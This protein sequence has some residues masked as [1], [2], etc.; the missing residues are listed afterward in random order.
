MRTFALMLLLLLDTSGRRSPQRI[1]VELGRG[2]RLEFVRVRA[3]T[4]AM[5]DAGSAREVRIPRDFWMQTTEVTQEQWTALG[6]ANRSEF[7][8]ERHP[9]HNVSWDD[10]QEFIAKLPV[11]A[12]QAALPAE[13]EWEYACRAG[14]KG[15]W[16]CGDA[17]SKL[18]DYAWYGQRGGEGTHPV[19]QKKPNAWGLHDMHGNVLEWVHDR[20]EEAG[21][22]VMRGGGW[23]GAA[24]GAAS[25]R[26]HHY[27]QSYRGRIN[28][29]R[30]IL[31]AR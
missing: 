1:V 21:H 27:E 11:R 24:D 31:R 25:A 16:C 23:F 2:I 17:E 18:D 30:V 3:G 15:R 13:A 26:R 6:F 20:S 12:R 14:S 9:V 7:A 8:G 4:F 29:F 19:A 5:G 28:G 22:R 10:A